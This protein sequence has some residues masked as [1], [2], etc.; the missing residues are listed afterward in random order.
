MLDSDPP[1]AGDKLLRFFDSDPVIA[2]EKLINC[3]KKL[4][5]RFAAERCSDAEDLADETLERVLEVLNRGEKQITTTIEAYISGF[6]THVLQEYWR[7][8]T[9]KEVSVDDLSPAIEPRT[10]SLEEL[11]L[12]FS[13]EEDLWNCLKRCLDE[14]PQTDREILLRYY[15]TELGQ[16]LKHVREQ[17]MHSLRLTSS[18]LRKR[19]F[20][21][22]ATLE[23]CIKDCLALR[24]R[25]QKS[26]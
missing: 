24:N 6:A 3:R 23:A 7:R 22:R 14:L 12:A 1:T 25:I 10:I 4:V 9:L 8:R 21:L 11:E 16:K 19:T 15:D 26:S 18:Q 2:A 20:T 17:M 13:Q 5:L